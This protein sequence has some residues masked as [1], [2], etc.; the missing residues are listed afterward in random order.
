MNLKYISIGVLILIG[1]LFY[2]INQ[3]N[4]ASAERLKQAET[5]HQQK[6]EQEKRA[7]AQ[8]KQEQFKKVEIDVKVKELQDRYLM[9]YLDAKGIIE[10][11]K[12]ELN[13][14]KFYADLAS[15]WSDAFKVAA[16]TPR[17][18]L[19]QPVKDMQLIK[20]DIES[21]QTK[22]FCESKMKDELV[23]SYDYAIDGF[24]QFMQKN[25]AISDVFLD[26]SNKSQ[27][28]ANMLIDY[29]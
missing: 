29:C 7:I 25:E 13:D 8:V 12:M 19:S 20:R 26:I 23:K 21:K 16:S 24:I 28:N 14:R 22:T 18:A 5:T 2:F 1:V 17:A 27:K 6:L 3:T 9:D 15:R 11:Q 4:K 10:S